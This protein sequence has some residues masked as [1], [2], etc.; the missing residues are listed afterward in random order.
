MTRTALPLS[1]KIFHWL[2]VALGYSE[3]HFPEGFHTSWSTFKNAGK[4]RVLR[5][6]DALVQDTAHMLGAPIEPGQL[7]RIHTVLRNWDRQASQQEDYG[8]PLSERMIAL[9]R[10]A[11]PELGT[12]LGAFGALSLLHC[13]DPALAEREADV[14]CHPMA[15]SFFGDVLELLLRRHRP[16]LDT[17]DKRYEALENETKVK[18][19]SQRSVERWRSKTQLSMPSPKLLPRLAKII[20]GGDDEAR[21]RSL[22]LLRYARAMTM[23]RRDLARWASEMTAE[24]F[25]T[26]VHLFAEHSMRFLLQ[27][28]SVAELIGSF[29]TGLENDRGDEILENLVPLLGPR[30]RDIGHR[31]LAYRMRARI[32][33]RTDDPVD[34][35]DS[36]LLLSQLLAPNPLLVGGVGIVLQAPNTLYVALGQ[37]LRIM[38]DQWHHRSVLLHVA[39]GHRLTCVSPTGESKQRSIP[40]E[41]QNIAA[42]LLE[43][44]SIVREPDHLPDLQQQVLH[45]MF[46]YKF[47]SFTGGK[48]AVDSITESI[49]HVDVRAYALDPNLERALDDEAISEIPPMIAARAARLAEEG[50]HT[51]AIGWMGRWMKSA[52][53]RTLGERM[54]IARAAVG[55]G[56][57]MIDQVAEVRAF[58]IE[59]FDVPTD[60]LPQKDLAAL[61]QTIGEVQA[62]LRT[63]DSQ[64]VK[65]ASIG[66]ATVG[67]AQV[68]LERAD[69]LALI[70]P[71]VLRLAYLK[72]DA[73]LKDKP[74]LSEAKGIAQAMQQLQEK[75]P[76]HG[77]LWGG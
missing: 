62:G 57:T 56:H 4:D 7:D 16:E 6:W 35:D 21:R 69:V 29:V 23:L 68:D 54:T 51:E 71:L 2:A 5:C 32:E 8:L 42:R 73:E 37:P 43:Q 11:T 65:L 52:S 20:S 38:A 63:I 39:K 17:W 15:P 33:E 26:A 10:L 40:T 27:R 22:G 19:I 60:E 72:A 74:D 48:E 25:T 13:P 49:Q 18:P 61:Q 12:R 70:F 14:L 9:L 3:E 31:E 28:E 59:D 44:D 64:V 66:I 46:L 58:F 34:Q 67:R 53:L 55:I 76:N 77:G 45:F 47:A 1:Q 41:L 30:I 50:H 75:L 24:Q 36:W